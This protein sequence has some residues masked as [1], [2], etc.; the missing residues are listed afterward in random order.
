MTNPHNAIQPTCYKPNKLQTQSQTNPI[1][2]NPII[3]NK[4]TMWQTP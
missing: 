4:P 3:S 1:K 2:E